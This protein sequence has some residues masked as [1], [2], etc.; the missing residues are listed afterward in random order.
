M[1]SPTRRV[2][3]AVT[4]FEEAP[5]ACYLYL[6]VPRSCR[7]RSLE[8]KQLLKITYPLDIKDPGPYVIIRAAYMN[9]V[10]MYPVS[11]DI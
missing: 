7:I 11:G 10:S 5:R 4:Q 8:H 1:F 9:T 3:R 2:G 6:R